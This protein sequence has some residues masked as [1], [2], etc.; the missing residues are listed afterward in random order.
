MKEEG[1]LLLHWLNTLCI[2]GE[3]YGV[4][5]RTI[6]NIMRNFYR[7]VR[8]HLQGTFVQFPSST[9]FRVLAQNLEALYGIL[10]IIGA[11]DESHIPIL[12]PIIGG[13]ILYYRKSLYLALL[14][15]IVDTKYV[16]SNFILINKS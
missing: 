9:Q 12:A 4:E 13:E 2:V 14:Q 10:H 3:V 6:S 7:L 8:V 1:G 15:G 16:Q 11:I 5:E